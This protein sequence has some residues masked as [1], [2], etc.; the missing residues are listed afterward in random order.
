MRSFTGWTCLSNPSTNHLA[1]LASAWLLWAMMATSLLAQPPLHVDGRRGPYHDHG[2]HGGPSGEFD[3]VEPTGAVTGRI[4]LR[5]DQLIYRHGDGRQVVYRRNGRYDTPDGQF[6]GYYNT[7]LARVLKF[8][9]SGFGHFL[10]ADLDD[11]TPFPQASYRLLHPVG[12]GPIGGP[13]VGPWAGGYMTHDISVYG[14]G[15]GLPWL[16]PAPAFGWGM[17]AGPLGPMPFAP[18]PLNPLPLSPI[19]LNPGPVPIDTRRVALPDLPPAKIRFTN[20]SQRDVNV[21]LSDA[22]QAGLSKTFRLG[23][24]ETHDMKLRRDAGH[25]WVETYELLSPDGQ[26]ITREVRHSIQPQPRYEIVVHEW[27]VQSVAIDRTARGNNR[28]EDINMQGKGIGRFLLPPGPE[29]TDQTI[30]VFQS[31]RAMQNQGTV[32]PLISDEQIQEQFRPSDRVSPFE[33]ALL[34]QQR[35]IQQ[36][37]QGQR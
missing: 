13:I 32:T 10:Y 18:F 35:A 9:R 25:E 14:G 16:A 19:P 34:Q 20:S 23:P 26:W 21:T 4:S 12:A 11:F 36:A 2:R 28:I 7:L 27:R 15:L 8:P 33:R 5:R 17:N 6:L 37:Q 31:A 24:A 3:L 1:S 30:D 29:L 22:R